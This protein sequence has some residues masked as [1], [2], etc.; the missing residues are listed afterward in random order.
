MVN[1]CRDDA[2]T[3]A[4]QSTTGTEPSTDSNGSNATP[5]KSKKEIAWAK[6]LALVCEDN[7][8]EMTNEDIAAPNRE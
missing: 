2:D 5:T 7:M 4:L 3:V 8:S 1:Q 6:A